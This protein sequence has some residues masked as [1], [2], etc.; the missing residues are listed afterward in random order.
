MARLFIALPIGRA[1][2][3]ALSEVATDVP[4][5][6][7]EVRPES[8]HLTLAFLGEVEERRVA[9]AERAM[10][11]SAAR[12]APLELSARGIGAFPNHERARVM[13][14]GLEGDVAALAE[15]QGDLTSALRQEGFDLEERPFRPHV[16]LAR[17]REPRPLPTNAE[18]SFG[19]WRAAEVRLY[20]SHLGPAGP[21]YEVRATAELE[22]AR[23]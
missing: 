3:D 12:A 18:R 15:L 8:L 20:E 17:S 2:V 4:R 16:T 9:A 19:G 21:R 5:G 6:W 7:R 1:V 14:A 11:L 22:D 10:R 23:E 13:W